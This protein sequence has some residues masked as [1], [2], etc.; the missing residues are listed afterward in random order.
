MGISRLWLVLRLIKFGVQFSGKKANALLHGDQSG[1]VV[2]CS[3]VCSAH[4]IG[5]MYSAGKD[6]RPGMVHFHARHVQKAWESLAELF[7]GTDCR[8]CVQAAVLVVSSHIYMCMPQ[9]ALLYIQKACEFIKAGD[10]RFVPTS[11]PMP[12]LSEELHETLAALSQTIYWANY[13]FLMFEGPEPRTTAKLERE[14][15]YKLLVG[16]SVPAFFPL[17]SCSA[18]GILPISLGDLSSDHSDMGH[19]AHKRCRP[20]CWHLPF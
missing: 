6:M 15:Q 5:M 10:L 19:P 13:L 4:V 18:A 3:F 16:R 17:S 20:A 14:F 1:T 7:N 2:N 8:T 12:E 9:M 11:G